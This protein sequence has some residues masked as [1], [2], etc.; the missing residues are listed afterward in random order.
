MAL[1]RVSAGVD[2][3]GRVRGWIY[4]NVSP[5]ITGQRNPNFTGVDSQATDGSLALA[6]DFLARRMEYCKHP[7]KVPVGYWRSVGHS[8]NCFAVE[9]AIDEL[10]LAAGK[11]PLAFRRKLLAN[12]PRE[13]N[14][15]N[16]AAALAD[17]S[18][19]PAAGRERGLAFSAAFGSLTAVAVEISAPTLKEIRVHKVA[20][21]VDCGF[22]VNPNAVEAQIQGGIVQGMSSSMWGRMTFTRGVVTPRN[23]DRSRVTRMREMPEIAVDIINSGEALGGIGE[24]GV[25]AVAPAIAN[26]YARLTGTR[27]RTLPFFP[28]Q[29]FMGDG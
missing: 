16:R 6:Y 11:D 15:L 13:L 2:A 4:R 27:L 5:S 28:D 24:P 3:T 9:S 18:T 7:A 20:C 22:A 12:A 21:A 23:F 25:P 29:S 19:R 1:I 14:V 10:A 8:I 26:A 17:W